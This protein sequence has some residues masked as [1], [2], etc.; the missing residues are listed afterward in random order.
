M[1]KWARGIKINWMTAGKY[2]SQAC[3][4]LKAKRGWGYL[5]TDE[6]LKHGYMSR[7]HVNAVS[8]D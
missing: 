5:S 6:L 3:A 4:Y 1:Q 2:I 8:L 7:I